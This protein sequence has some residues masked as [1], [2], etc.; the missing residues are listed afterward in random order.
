MLIRI[1]IW[2]GCGSGC[3]SIQVT[4]MVRIPPDA[5]PDP[6]NTGFYCVLCT[7]RT[8]LS[9]LC[10]VSVYR[11]YS[12]ERVKLGRFLLNREGGKAPFLAHLKAA[13]VDPS[14]PLEQFRKARIWLPGSCHNWFTSGTVYS[15]LGCRICLM[16]ELIV[17]VYYVVNWYFVY[18]NARHPLVSVNFNVTAFSPC[19]HIFFFRW[20]FYCTAFSSSDCFFILF[21]WNMLVKVGLYLW[22]KRISTR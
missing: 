4:K 6:Q 2:C 7:G 10:T 21:V 15:G 3:G 11:A 1:F 22:K 20:F 19:K 8:V 13:L 14:V 17:F 9:I 12:A 16:S 18:L 5:D